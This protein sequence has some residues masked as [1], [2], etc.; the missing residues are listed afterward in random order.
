MDNW[1]TVSLFEWKHFILYAWGCD[2]E[3]IKNWCVSKFYK[4]FY[5]NV[6]S[7]YI[8]SFKLIIIFMYKQV[9][10]FDICPIAVSYI[11]YSTN[12]CYWFINVTLAWSQLPYVFTSLLISCIIYISIKQVIHELLQRLWHHYSNKGNKRYLKVNLHV[13][14]IMSY[15]QN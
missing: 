2:K 15:C 14:N 4:L 11:H 1:W 13:I 7:I 6:Q 10:T 8:K 5:Y 9:M 12:I 3:T